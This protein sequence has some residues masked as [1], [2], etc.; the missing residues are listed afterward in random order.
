MTEFVL[1]STPKTGRVSQ[2]SA[3]WEFIHNVLACEG[4]FQALLVK[5]MVF[6]KQFR[7]ICV[8][9]SVFLA[10]ACATGS[11]GT[12]SAKFMVSNN[13]RD[14]LSDVFARATKKAV[15]LPPTELSTLAIEKLLKDYDKEIAKILNAKQLDEFEAVHRNRF[16]KRIYR[17]LTRNPLEGQRSTGMRPSPSEL[18]D[19]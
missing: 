9:S 18:I 1:R 10:V 8:S 19:Y 12:D 17:D 5:N 3:R 13:Q 6:A 11:D 7:C 14:A 4:L 16:A 15:R 2:G